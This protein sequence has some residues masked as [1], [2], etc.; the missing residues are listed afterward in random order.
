MFCFARQLLDNDVGPQ[1]YVVIYDGESPTD[2]L[3]ARFTADSLKQTV[4]STSRIILVHIRTETVTEGRGFLL[5]YRQ[6]WNNTYI[7]MHQAC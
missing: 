4:I 1:D 2:P 6:G 7:Y 3:L 5:S